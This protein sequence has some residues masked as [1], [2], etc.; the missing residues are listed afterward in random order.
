MTSI[1]NKGLLILKRSLI[2]KRLLILIF[3][4]LFV[5]LI[6]PSLVTAFEA[7]ISAPR[8]AYSPYETFQAEIKFNEPPQE[9]P[10]ILNLAL[11]G[12][13][14]KKVS[15]SPA[16][17]R[18]SDTHY[19]AYFD[20]PYTKRGTYFFS[21][22]NMLYLD[23]KEG[24]LK[25]YSQKTDFFINSTNKGFEYVLKQQ[26]P[27]GYFVDVKNAKATFTA[28]L[29]IKNVYPT[30]AKKAV[31]YFAVDYLKSNYTFPPKCFPA[32]N[33]KV[34][35]TVYSMLALKEFGIQPNPDPWLTGAINKF[36]QGEWTITISSY[37]T[38]CIVNRHNYAISREEITIP[39][40]SRT[41]NI[42]CTTSSTIKIVNKYL[43]YSHTLKSTS[44]PT[45]LTYTIDDS[46]CWG[47]TY[48]SP[49]DY[50]STA[51]AVW[52]LKKF[53]KPIEQQTLDWLKKN[54]GEEKTINHALHYL[55]TGD[56]YSKEWLLVNLKDNYWT[57][58]PQGTEPDL[59]ASAIAAY[60]LE[61]DEPGI[62]RK[63]AYFLDDKT[64]GELLTSS[65]ILH[66]FFS[67]QAKSRPVSIN[68]G[69]V[70]QRNNF[71][72]NLE[73]R[74][75]QEL[76]RID[77]PNFT[78]LPASFTLTGKKSLNVIV[79]ENQSSFNI[80]IS[81]QDKTYT[82][83][84]IT[85]YIPQ[86][87]KKETNKTGQEVIKKE[88]L[89]LPPP[90]DSILL[91]VNKSKFPLNISKNK[92][93]ITF[94]LTNQWNYPLHNITFKLTG[95]L[96]QLLYIKDQPIRSIEPGEIKSHTIGIKQ[97]VEEKEF[98]GLLVVSSE[99]GTETTMPL[100]AYYT[101]QATEEA[102]M[103]INLA[104]ETTEEP[105]KENNQIQIDQDKLKED[106]KKRKKTSKIITISIIS[107]I[108]LVAL[109]FLIFLKKRIITT[110]TFDEYSKGFGK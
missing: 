85:P 54:T 31:D 23:E 33:C 15:I 104:E 2:P 62:Y 22:E 80:I 41:I 97:G 3:A 38:T 11:K 94:N 20:I 44:L 108:I 63:V 48:K 75:S 50:E 87:E 52:M 51:Y 64:Q 110:Q 101:A 59:Y 35:D 88:E 19:F 29:A 45:N 1:K 86:E 79:P 12:T 46:M 58:S 60:A 10:T 98:I 67:G 78:N 77:A 109:L 53:N 61:Q 26:K 105:G 21:L 81:Y 42:E 99:E 24:V 18:L 14:E 49:C 39:L 37:N 92:E 106:L 107:F 28:A 27:E 82:L 100:T 71:A 25:T 17:V 9:R 74:D 6:I 91:L 30:E 16:L 103:E 7:T 13:D 68:P 90:K 73:S 93:I 5:F 72:L 56:S 76:I 84:V 47:E 34:M 43:G 65:L 40:N 83:P 102:T 95:N 70:Y 4:S 57:S 96:N 8:T 32:G 89:L 36:N 69:I 66:F 55:A